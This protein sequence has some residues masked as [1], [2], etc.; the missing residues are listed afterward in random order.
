MP[1]NVSLD[2][3][4]EDTSFCTQCGEHE[5]NCEAEAKIA[6]ER[7]MLVQDQMLKK[8]PTGYKQKILCP[9]C[10]HWNM[11]GKP[12]CCDTLRKAV[13]AILSGRRALAIAAAQERA[14]VN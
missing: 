12:F 3:A 7:L 4:F 1:D 13:I 14:S 10:G 11:K 8:V 6:Y 5:C 9:Y 2:E